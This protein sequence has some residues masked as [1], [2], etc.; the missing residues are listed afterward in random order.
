[1]STS[2]A[3]TSQRPNKAGAALSRFMESPKIGWAALA[4]ALLIPFIIAT[5]YSLNVMTTAAHMHTKA[6]QNT[7]VNPKCPA[8]A[9]A[10]AE[11]AATK[12]S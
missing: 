4:I 1:M 3:R 12:R 5:P 6:N 10:T 2:V 11:L 7:D 8:I 9:P